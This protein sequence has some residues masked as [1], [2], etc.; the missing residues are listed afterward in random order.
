MPILQINH[1]SLDPIFAISCHPSSPVLAIGSATGNVILYRYDGSKLES[2]TQSNAK[3]SPPDLPAW[4]IV[5]VIGREPDTEDTADAL[6]VGWAT[7]R[8][9]QSCRDL[10]FDSEGARLYTAG[11]EG[12]IK[13]ADVTTGKVVGKLQRLDEQASVSCLCPAPNKPFLLVGDDDGSIQCYDTRTMKEAYKLD[14][15]H[16]ECVSFVVDYTPRSDYQF[17]SGGGTTVANW[18]FRKPNALHT[19]ESQDDEVLCGSWVNIEQ[20]DTLLCGMGAGPVTV[21]R[22]KLNE[23][24]DQISRIKFIKEENVNSI[25]S[26]MDGSSVWGGLSNG[27]IMKVRVGDGRKLVT[28]SHSDEAIETLEM[29]SSY[30]L[31]SQSMDSVL[32]WGEDEGH[33][34]SEHDDD[35][36]SFSDSSDDSAS[37]DD[38]E[39]KAPPAKKLKKE[40]KPASVFSNGIAQFDDL[41]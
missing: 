22:P 21:W 18:D 12:I 24:E 19:S 20:P 29:D 26:A 40:T 10:K 1:S 30:R 7:R 28:L 32:I 31:V 8:H 33:E 15:V 16:N 5:D 13:Q 11:K 27:S 14:K 23:W 25:L 34:D 35:E 36:S 37:S 9:K 6:M 17:V 39:V 2:L 4:P 3:I 38:S 41:E